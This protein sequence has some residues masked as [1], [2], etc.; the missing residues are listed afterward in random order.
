M[1]V[2]VCVCVCARAC[3]HYAVFNS[4]S[5]P[6]L[7]EEEW[8]RVRGCWAPVSTGGFTPPS[9]SVQAGQKLGLSPSPPPSFTQNETFV[10]LISRAGFQ[11]NFTWAWSASPICGCPWGRPSSFRLW[12]SQS[13]CRRPVLTPSGAASQTFHPVT[14]PGSEAACPQ[15]GQSPA[16]VLRAA[17]SGLCPT[18]CSLLVLLELGWKLGLAET[19]PEAALLTS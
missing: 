14:R 17:W 15:P 7:M 5:V 13:C 8:R 16:S 3:A 6:I 9:R 1:C 4:R 2:C 12:F 18:P 11:F 19:R 10:V